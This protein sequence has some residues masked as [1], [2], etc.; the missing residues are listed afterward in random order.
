MCLTDK[1]N[2]QTVVQ[3]LFSLSLFIT[4]GNFENV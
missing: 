4:W 3:M 1:K 2:R